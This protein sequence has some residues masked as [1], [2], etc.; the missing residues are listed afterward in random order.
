LGSGIAEFLQFPARP[1]GFQITGRDQGNQNSHAPEPFQK[2]IG[3][4]VI[5]VQFGIAPDF[6]LFPQKLPH[7]YRERAMKVANPLVPLSRT[8][9]V[10]VS[11]TDEDLGIE[12]H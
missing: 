8:L 2:R 7:T 11:V 9:V 10:E 12:F 1:F 3:E 6:R 4:D 5:A